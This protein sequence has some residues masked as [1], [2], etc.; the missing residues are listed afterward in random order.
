MLPYHEATIGVLL[1][2]LDGM[3]VTTP[4]M[5]Q[6]NFYGLT[7]CLILYQMTFKTH[8]IH[9]LTTLILL[10]CWVSGCIYLIDKCGSTVLIMRSYLS[11]TGSHKEWLVLFCF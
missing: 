2:P 9:S 1:L 11:H 3:L 7:G 8:K 10:I 4:L 5:C 6:S